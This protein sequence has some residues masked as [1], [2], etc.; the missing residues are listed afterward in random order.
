MSASENNKKI[1]D[2]QDEIDKYEV[3]LKAELE[4]YRLCYTY[5]NIDPNTI[6]SNNKCKGVKTD[7]SDCRDCLKISEDRIVK[8]L[9]NI[10][11]IQNNIINEIKD[12]TADYNISPNF[13]E[14]YKNELR[15]IVKR[16][17]NT[18]ETFVESVELYKLYR[19]RIISEVI[20]LL[21]ILFII[22]YLLKTTEGVKT[23]TFISSIL[24]ITL[25]SL[26]VFY[27][28]YAL[29][30]FSVLSYIMFVIFAIMNINDISIN[31]QNLANKTA[32]TISNV[33]TEFKKDVNVL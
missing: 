2:F 29:F 8:L 1:N 3:D 24:Y 33:S 27:P 13:S 6:N 32:D 30:I 12:L 21:I 19:I 5:F 15:D 9:G 18:G 16:Y 31:Y 7:S 4:H 11:G 23:M 25:S 10:Q 28:S 14:E 17:K 22:F 26:E 20:K